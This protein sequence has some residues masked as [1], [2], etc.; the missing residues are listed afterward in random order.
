M[1]IIVP[2]QSA[3]YR[4][5]QSMIEDIIFDPSL[6]AKAIFNEDM[7]E[8]QKLRL[9]EYVWT[10][11]VEDSSGFSS[12]KTRTFFIAWVLRCIL[13]ENHVSGVY[14]QNFNSGQ[15][16]FWQ[17]FTVYQQKS[18]IFREQIGRLG[19]ETDEGDEKKDKKG[20]L[21]GPSCWSCY[22]KNG[23]HLMM[24]APG[25][26]RESESQA[27]LRLNDLGLDE[28]TKSEAMGDNGINKQ[29]IG[30]ATRESY[31]QD[32]PFWCN[33]FL[34]L[35]TA[36]DYKHP[37]AAR[38]KKY[39]KQVQTGDPYVSQFSF[40]FKDISDL[41]MGDTGKSWK[42]TLR[43]NKT[44]KEMKA[45]LSPTKYLQEVL[46]IW[47]YS[48]IGWY[49]EENLDG[50]VYLGQSRGL[51]PVCSRLQDKVYG[52]L[53]TTRYF[54]GV[55]P[56]RAEGRKTD[57]G[58]MVVLRAIPKGPNPEDRLSDWQLDYVWAY[59]VRRAD[60]DQWSGLIHKKHLDFTF[61]G[62]C[63]DHG[64]GGIW[65]K[66]KLAAIK[67]KIGD[68]EVECM[69]IA[70]KDD[71]SVTE[72]DYCLILFI[73]G[74]DSIKKK[75]P[76]IKG[77]DNLIDYSHTEFRD[78]MHH[79]HIAYP[80]AFKDIPN[81]VKAGWDEQRVWAS[82]LLDL[83]RKQLAGIKV[84]T[85]ADGQFIFTRNNAHLF[86]SKEKKDFGYAAVH[87]FVRF[88]VWLKCAD[89]EHG[90]DDEQIAGGE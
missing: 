40:S 21:K 89:E 48:G 6:A 36:E 65:I 83:C 43:V 66:P 32:H 84:A 80:P 57:D 35:A 34:F 24:P 20:T 72:A 5:P 78:A 51:L 8:F 75:W 4:L 69:P 87:A 53:E 2:S 15:K 77:P 59:K 44:L 67:Q 22:F 10:P 50:T 64:G 37:A 45:N 82:K 63:M 19:L 1:N 58:A 29:L 74:D 86:D 27:G 26:L 12:F 62:I 61:S 71:I 55:D 56:A 54:M 38:H 30:R 85:E 46:G 60:V 17:Y 33:H 28:W 23:S 79:S 49:S 73:Q 81:E 68:A 3:I 41:P 47:G 11:E 18:K 39:A 14:Y 42:K 70:T 76:S 90:L 7:D 31:N 16:N 9:R 88:V 52:H 13:I 25:F